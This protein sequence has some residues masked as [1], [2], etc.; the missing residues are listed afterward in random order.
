[1]RS[2]IRARPARLAMPL[3]RTRTACRLAVSS[4]SS[5]NEACRLSRDRQNRNLPF[6]AVY[7]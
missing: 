6:V 3:C 2:R 4:T 5:K 1:M 7:G